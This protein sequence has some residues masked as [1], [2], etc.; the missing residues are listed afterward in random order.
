ML[1]IV[2]IVP[3]SLIKDITSMEKFTLA[4]VIL[5]SIYIFTV[6]AYSSLIILGY[7]ER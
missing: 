4:G 6:I 2:I 7:D 3:L 1:P 5:A